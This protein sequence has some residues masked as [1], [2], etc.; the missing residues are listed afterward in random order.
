MTLLPLILVLAIFG[1]IVWIILQINMPPI[2]KNIII[3][4]ASIFVIVFLLQQ[5]GIQTGLPAV[6]LW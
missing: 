6:K 4:I 2:V 1:F 5:F 3:G